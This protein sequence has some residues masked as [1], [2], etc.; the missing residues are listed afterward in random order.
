MPRGGQLLGREDFVKFYPQPAISWGPRRDSAAKDA[1][2]ELQADADA[3]LVDAVTESR[4]H[5]RRHFDAAVGER[6]GRA[7]AVEMRHEDQARADGAGLDEADQAKPGGNRDK[8]DE[9]RFDHV[10]AVFAVKPP[11]ATAAARSAASASF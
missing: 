10:P 8:A 7:R 6:G 11:L 1:M 2:H 3:R 5:V 9:A 4:A